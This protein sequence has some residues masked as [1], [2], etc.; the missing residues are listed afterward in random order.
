M[1]FGCN[2]INRG[3]HTCHYL[4]VM[5]WLWLRVRVNAILVIER[6]SNMSAASVAALEEFCLLAKTARGRACEELVKQVKYTGWVPSE[7]TCCLGLRGYL[8]A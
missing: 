3:V 8:R 5:V 2:Y 1:K 7:L 4:W 6:V